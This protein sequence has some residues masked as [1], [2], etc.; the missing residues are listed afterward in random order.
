[1]NRKWTEANRNK[2]CVYRLDYHIVFVVKYRRKCIN[3][4]IGA[5]LINEAKRIA[6]LKG[7][8]LIEGNHDID[9]VHLLVSLPPNLNLA[10]V[11]G[12]MKMAMSK[13]VRNRYGDYLKQHLWGD[14]FWTTSYYVATTGGANLETIRKYVE[15][16]GTKPRTKRAVKGDILE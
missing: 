2:H 4:E 11:I 7:G 8:V 6:E 16:Q 9:H 13:V 15:S 1:M 3:D 12:T 14:A 5:V 10:D